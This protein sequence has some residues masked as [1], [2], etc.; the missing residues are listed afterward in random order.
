MKIALLSRWYWEENRRFGAEGGPVR[1]LAEA[2]AARGH[3]VVVLSQSPETR[4]L[5]KDQIGALETWLSPR[6][7]KRS[8]VIG[9]RDK[10]AKKTYHYRKVHSDAHALH[11]FLHRRGPFD[12]LWAQTESPDGL[13]AGFAK[14]LGFEVPPIL[15]QIQALRYR[16]ERGAPVFTEKAPLM[17]AFRH[18]TRIIANSEMIAGY[19]GAYTGP[20]L[21]PDEL[22]AKVRVAYPNLYRG[23][24]EAAMEDP[25]HV[26]PRGDRVLF[27]G[28]LNVGKGALVFL[29]ALPKTEMSKRSA[30]F[31][32]I[33]DFTE[34]N[35]AFAKRW[36]QQKEDT[37]V[38]TLGARIEYLGKVTPEEVIRQ[39]RLAAAV[40]V[41]SLFDAFNRGLTEALLLGRPVVT[42]DRVGA[43][44]LVHA[45]QCGIVV[46]PNDPESLGHAIDAVTSPLV[47]FARN[48][49]HIG[50]QLLH[51]FT[52]ETV[53]ARMEHNL[54]RT[55]GLI[56]H[57]EGL[58][59]LS[60]PPQEEQEPQEPAA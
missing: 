24:L 30:V 5:R 18:A 46:P 20:S 27:L 11:E 33:G 16:F 26:A 48:A 59:P 51:E 34:D 37:R 21:P 15:L 40:V 10:L 44:A 43:A 58:D 28:A 39:I 42:T 47:P 22:A 25:H 38:Q 8:F 32:I 1:Q 56:T 14:Q 7:K 57:P 12:V 60:G 23:F 9:W 3:E 29:R 45:H 52:P 53:A 6:D 55:A 35:K 50:P 2:V 19:L 49:A 41:P 17:L 13:V 54:A 31:A 36:E 4:K